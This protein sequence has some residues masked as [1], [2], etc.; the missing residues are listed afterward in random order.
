MEYNS[1]QYIKT[2]NANGTEA[3]SAPKQQTKGKSSVSGTGLRNCPLS[4]AFQKAIRR[5]G[6]LFLVREKG[7]TVSILSKLG[8]VGQVRRIQSCVKQREGFD[9]GGSL[10]SVV[11]PAPDSRLSVWDG[12]SELYRHY[13]ATVF[14]ADHSQ[15]LSS[16][17][18]HQ[19]EHLT[20]ARD[21][22][23]F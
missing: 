9:R 21:L 23:F 7:E 14:K 10:P 6:A 22:N 1:L 12:P 8:Q 19:T 13:T 11:L 15:R 20:D 17:K 5:I 3:S 18:L 4:D 2:K 16:V